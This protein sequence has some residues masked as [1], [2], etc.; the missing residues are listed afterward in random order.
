MSPPATH[1]Y[2][3]NN[4]RLFHR[5]DNGELRAK[6]HA[7]LIEEALVLQNE[8]FVGYGLV[9]FG[10][11]NL[12]FGVVN[13]WDM[14]PAA[15]G[16]LMKSFNEKGVQWYMYPIVLVASSGEIENKE[17]LVAEMGLHVPE[18]QLTI[19]KRVIACWG[20]QH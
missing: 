1:S 14:S 2:D 12:S 13:R 4:K 7:K 15:V 10:M 20:G 16:M 18:I 5:P 17:S 9:R 3:C 11:M 8:A 19:T 6:Q